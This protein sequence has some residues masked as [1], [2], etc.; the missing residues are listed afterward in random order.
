MALT[1]LALCYTRDPSGSENAWRIGLSTKMTKIASSRDVS[2]ESSIAKAYLVEARR[3]YS[4]WGCQRMVTRL[5]HLI[6]HANEEINDKTETRRNRVQ[7]HHHSGGTH[8][9]D[10]M[11]SFYDDGAASS[12]SAEFHLRHQSCQASTV[13]SSSSSSS[14]SHI[15]LPMSL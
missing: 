7:S 11:S 4:E 8:H 9:T 15:S 1:R 5:A 6:L 13:S 14:V 2:R 10:I 12:E 3:I